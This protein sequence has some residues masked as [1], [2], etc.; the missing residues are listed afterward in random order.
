MSVS[1]TAKGVSSI[2]RSL[3]SS[4]RFLSAASSAEK[5]SQQSSSSSSSS[6]SQQHSS[7]RRSF[8]STA[9]PASS[10]L[11]D[12]AK[13]WVRASASAAL[14]EKILDV[15]SNADKSNKLWSSNSS[16]SSS[17]G[18]SSSGNSNQ[19][20]QHQQQSPSSSASPQ[21][22]N[23]TLIDT[24]LFMY[25]DDLD[26]WHLNDKASRGPTDLPPGVRPL[27]ERCD[28]FVLVQEEMASLSG[29]IQDLVSSD[30]PVLS[31]VAKY[32]FELDSGKK[33]RPVMVLLMSHALSAQSS[34]SNISSSNLLP[35]QVRLAEIA[36]MI[37]TAS[38]FHDDVIDKADT[39]RGVPSVNKMF[40]NKM[41]ILAGDFLLARASISLARLRNCDVVEV[42]STIIE[43][44]VKGEVMQM[45]VLAKK[46]GNDTPDEL[47]SYYL[48]KNYYKT[49]S[50]MAN[51]CMS[52]ALLRGDGASAHDINNA[53][54][55][56]KHVGLA[57]QLVDDVLDFEG[58][59]ESLGK[60]ALADL[61]S[62]L[63]T[64]PVLFAA[65]KHPQ[66]YKLIERKFE[67]EGDIAEA[68][69]LVADSD[70]IARTKE[71]ALVHAERA[72]E[73]VMQLEESEYRDGLV[74]LAYK[75]INREN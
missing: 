48:K 45:R 68:M 42:M 15:A 29:D 55:Y 40:G 38:L 41:A 25:S 23:P 53:Y 64:A 71:L 10:S 72:C 46:A 62:G 50:L 75:I 14:E 5:T 67:G 56:G 61:T 44:L 60:P 33:V 22:P 7:R 9:A 21:Q 31:Q 39:R 65:Q 30:H 17:S 66:L 51:S 54:L 52:A 24:P 34:S 59:V 8:T 6:S 58:N 20:Q 35:M 74:H 2:A 18:S 4:S 43:H 26:E 3:A 1:L 63:A 11:K 19:Q 13:D 36:E 16:S 37:H 73:A 32:F 27:D 47:I 69:R 28:P 12:Y 49:G 57:F 70:G